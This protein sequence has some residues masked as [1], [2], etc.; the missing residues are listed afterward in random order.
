MEHTS[1]YILIEELDADR[2]GYVLWWMPDRE[3]GGGERLI[4]RAQR[5]AMNRMVSDVIQYTRDRGECDAP[6]RC[7]SSVSGV[8]SGAVVGRIAKCARKTVINAA[9]RI[10]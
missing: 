8:D 5:A 9:S 10:R 2:V 6:F 1:S 7:N 4:E 3:Q